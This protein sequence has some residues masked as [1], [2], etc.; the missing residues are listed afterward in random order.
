MIS[1]FLKVL[2]AVFVFL[3]IAPIAFVVM[4]DIY[5]PQEEITKEVPKDRYL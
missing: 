1:T 5:L 4:S 3:V 2:F